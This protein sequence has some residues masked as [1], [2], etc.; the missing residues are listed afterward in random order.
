MNDSQRNMNDSQHLMNLDEGQEGSRDTVRNIVGTRETTELMRLNNR[1][2]LVTTVFQVFMMDGTV[3]TVTPR[4]R[5][6]G[7]DG[8]SLY[9]NV[10]ED[11][12]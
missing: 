5:L 12:S 6:A 11:R 1:P 9:L 2:R 4:V 8:P 10:V 3:L 7:E